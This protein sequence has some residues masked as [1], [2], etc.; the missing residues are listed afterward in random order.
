MCEYLNSAF[1]DAFT[2]STPITGISPV[3]ENDFPMDSIVINIQGVFSG[4]ENLKISPSCG[5]E[6]IITKALTNT[7]FS[8]GLYLKDI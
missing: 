6:E 7:K 3:I 4:I 5:I 1:S 8:S 2:I